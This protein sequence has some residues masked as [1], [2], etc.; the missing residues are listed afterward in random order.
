M[1]TERIRT[2]IKGLDD[3]W[4]GF[5]EGRTMIL[6]GDAGSGK[7]IFGLQ[8]ANGSCAQ[9][10]RTAYVTT[11]EGVED[12]KL[13]AQ[14]FDW[15]IEKWVSEGLLTFIDVLDKRIQDINAAL[16][17]QVSVQ[18][19]NFDSLLEPVPKGTQVIIIDS[20]G[21]H[22]A[23][24]TPREFKDRFDVLVHKIREKHLTALIIIDSV[25]SE[26]HN[27][28]ALFS[29]YGALNLIKREN[30]YTGQR[31]R[32]IDIIKMRNTKVPLQPLVYEIDRQ[33]IVIVTQEQ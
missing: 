20:L 25:T 11:E 12:L 15:K 27:D 14:S 21:S 32:V 19:G 9:G 2:G 29:A 31:E 7:T 13:Q 17:I 6:T 1:S 8:F 30:A 24:L 4:G 28:L 22:T 26:T 23:Q 33:G 16:E 5:P 10:Y 3:D 18:K